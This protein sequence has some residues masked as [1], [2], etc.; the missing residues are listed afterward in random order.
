MGIEDEIK[1]LAKSITN[2][3]SQSV[4]DP[5]GEELVD[6]IK[7]RTRLGKGVK[8]NFGPSH[9][10]P[11][12]QDKT[13]ANRRRLKKQG[14]LTGPKATPAKSGLNRT[15]QMLDSMT[16]KSGEN[17]LEIKLDALGEKKAEELIALDSQWTFMNISKAEFRGLLD[18]F[19]KSV[20]NKLGKL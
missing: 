1:K 4:L 18:S 5:L 7:K 10:L 9:A 12:L 14:K 19:V 2:L 8:D 16:H 11:K 6:R 15:G 13:K 3:G 20:Q 17:S